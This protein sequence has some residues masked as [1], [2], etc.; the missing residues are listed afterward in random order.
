MDFLSDFYDPNDTRDYVKSPFI[1]DGRTI[2]TDSR[3]IVSAPEMEG[4]PS[5][6]KYKIADAV[7]GLFHSHKPGTFS[8]FNPKFNQIGTVCNECEGIGLFNVTDCP[9]CDNEGVLNFST[10][11]NDY[12]VECE[13]C[14][15]KG[16]E[17][18]PDPEGK[19]V[20]K[21]CD[22]SGLIYNSVEVS[23]LNFK[24]KY[25][26]AIS[27]IEGVKVSVNTNSR[28]LFFRSNDDVNG[29]VMAMHKDDR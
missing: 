19:T 27:K 26:L 15:G 4:Y 16:G 5:G 8:E 3:C 10:D 1:L 6:N 13:T 25:I 24:R 2:A 11:Y 9:E 23:G 28:M 21:K 17:R 20:C 18:H 12:E 14:W 29:I 22:G 7:R